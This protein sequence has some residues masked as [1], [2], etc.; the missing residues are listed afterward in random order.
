MLVILYNQLISLKISVGGRLVEY[1]L[2]NGALHSFFALDQC[3]KNDVKVENGETFGVQLADGL[4]VHAVGKICFYVDLGPMKTALKFY[5]LDRNILCVL[6]I[7]FLQ[8]VNTAIDW[9]NH[10]VEVSTVLG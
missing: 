4:E 7:L 3:Q 5:V 10:M 2:D 1:L 9:V 6:G 8:M